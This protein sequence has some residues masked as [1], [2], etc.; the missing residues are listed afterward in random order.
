[1]RGMR[2]GFLERTR[3]AAGPRPFAVEL[4]IRD[5]WNLGSCMRM[6][7]QSSIDCRKYCE[8]PCGLRIGS[9]GLG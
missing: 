8:R 5:V 9:G 2:G 7:S 4:E 6:F 3:Y 1:V